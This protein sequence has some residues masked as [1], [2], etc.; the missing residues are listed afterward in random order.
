[1][2]NMKPEINLSS[3]VQ[4]LK[5]VGPVRARGL[6]RLGIETV[7]DLLHHYPRAYLDRSDRTPVS[8]CQVGAE[9]TI[10][11]EVMT[12]GERKTR[13]GGSLQT[14]TV[15]D[16][17][18]VLFCVW[19]NQRYVLKQFRGG[20][21][22]MMSGRVQVHGGR[23]QLMHPDFEILDGKGQILHTGRLVPVYPLTQG[24]G[25]HWLRQLIH[26]CLEQ[27]PDSGL[28]T[29]PRDELTRISDTAWEAR[30]RDEP[31]KEPPP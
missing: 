25:Q 17:T 9:V 28:E 20:M 16:G 14:V 7:A 3:P 11:G 4:F 10:V 15:S 8:R 23:R 5:T 24:I 22:V 12:A 30:A 18:G 31:S 29:L 1:M 6:T 19:F 2:G 27:I 21:Q 26:N 13:R